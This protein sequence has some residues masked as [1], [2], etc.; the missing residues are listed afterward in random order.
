[1]NLEY[2][3][4]EDIN[5]IKANPIDFNYRILG[6]ISDNNSSSDLQ[7]DSYFSYNNFIFK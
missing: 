3:S 2:T 5:T 7:T 6:Q 4:N 1:M